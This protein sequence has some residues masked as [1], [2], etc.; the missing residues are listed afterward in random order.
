[1]FKAAY[2]VF[3]IGF[4]S[5]ALISCGG[6]S[7]GFDSSNGDTNGLSN[8]SGNG[9]GSSNTVPTVP[10]GNETIFLS[11]TPPTQ[12]TDNSDLTDLT[13]YKVYYGITSTSLTATYTVTDSSASSATVP[14]LASNTKYFFSIK[15]LNS[16]NVE[17]D[18]SN[19]VS[20]TT[21]G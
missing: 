14:S 3:I 1:M 6:G 5:L 8:I 10:S 2:K 19:I 13:G 15:V 17:S 9:G 11:W 12:N 20:K 4:A 21:A 16:K 18:F 7:S